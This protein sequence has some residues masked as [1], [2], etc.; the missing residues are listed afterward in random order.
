[1]GRKNHRRPASGT[2]AAAKPAGGSRAVGARSRADTSDLLDTSLEELWATIASAD[3]LEAAV[4]MFFSDSG[5]TMEVEEFT[6]PA[7]TGCPLGCA[8]S[9]IAARI[10]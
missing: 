9:V 8:N 2:G 3:V 6:R 4:A 10:R 5:S 1:M 7:G